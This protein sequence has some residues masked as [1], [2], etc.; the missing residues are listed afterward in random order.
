[1]DSFKKNWVLY[2]S[3]L[4]LV[5]II[6]ISYQEWLFSMSILTKGDWFFY[7]KESLLTI[8]I[9]YFLVWYP[10][11]EFGKVLLDAGQAPIY[12]TAGLLTKLFNFEWSLIERIIYI[13]PIVILTPFS[14]FVLT[15]KILNAN[16]HLIHIS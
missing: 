14:A 3:I 5:S 9:N 2:L 16:I 6:A 12:S 7:F 11:Q 13:W 8:R 15:R 1:M 4:L 10:A